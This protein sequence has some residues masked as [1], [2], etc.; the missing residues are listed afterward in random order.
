MRL[1]MRAGR[2]GFES[3]RT[4]MHIAAITADPFHRGIP[5]EHPAILDIVRQGDIPPFVLTLGHGN[6]LENRRDIVVSFL[7]RNTSE[8]RIHLRL[9][10]ML[11][12]RRRT[13]VFQRGSDLSRREGCGDFGLSPFEEFEQTL[14][15]FL[16]LVRR[17]L[18][19]RGNLNKPFVLA[20]LEAYV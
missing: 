15:M 4:L 7:A 9:L 14:G 5:L 13:E 6:G 12:R 1:S 18:E 3:F 19:D 16:F 2:A 20:W 8:I 11:A 10:M 17:F